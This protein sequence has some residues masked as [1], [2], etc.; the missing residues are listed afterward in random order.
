M[1]RTPSAEYLILDIETIPDVERWKRP[2]VTEGTP[3]P[4][5]AFPPTWA[6]RIVVIG[7]RAC[8]VDWNAGRSHKRRVDG[9]ESVVPVAGL[10]I[11][12]DVIAGICRFLA[13]LLIGVIKAFCIGLGYS[14]LTLVVEFL[15]MAIVL[16]L[17][18]WG[19]LGQPEK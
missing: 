7:I 1:A 14:K 5:L 11:R 19:L 12:Q 16:V 13:A 4:K 3:E 2:E 8:S 9:F 18:P 15:V 10:G 6:H 17:R